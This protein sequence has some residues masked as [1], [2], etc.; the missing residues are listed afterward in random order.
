RQRSIASQ[1][2]ATVPPV[3]PSPTPNLDW[4]LANV[5]RSWNRFRN[6]SD[7]APSLLAGHLDRRKERHGSASE[8]R[9][10]AA[11]GG[12]GDHGRRVGASHCRAA[13]HGSTAIWLFHSR[14]LDQG[15]GSG[16]EVAE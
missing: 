11:T 9:R 2:A 7:S 4:N 6:G 13:H 5:L 12:L 10:A 14:Q 8:D 1:A 16:E 3:R 15:Q